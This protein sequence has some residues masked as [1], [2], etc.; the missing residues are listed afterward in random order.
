MKKTIVLGL[1]NVLYGDE[2]LGVRLTERL[3][4]RHSFL[5][6]L[7]IV[8]GGTRGLALLPYI[9][10]AEKMLV[11]D[12]VDMSLSP[13]TS[14]ILEGKAV[15]RW[16][17]T[18]KLSLHQT[19]F[20]ELLA[21]ATF[22]KTLPSKLILLG[23]QPA[24]LTYG[25]SLSPQLER[26]LP[27]LE[28]QCLTLLY[29]LGH[30]ACIAKPHALLHAPCLLPQNVLPALPHS[31]ALCLIKKALQPAYPAV[32]NGGDGQNDEACGQAVPQYQQAER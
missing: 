14:V 20:A 23:V 30:T 31:S 21:L 3:D 27:D 28:E 22:R 24:D 10:Q 25:S 1:G 4:R 26:Q 7:E 12:A 9:E 16:L 11:L 6:E 8:D 13:G 5:P 32:W 29:R 17:A 19:S 15:P 18:R 2:G